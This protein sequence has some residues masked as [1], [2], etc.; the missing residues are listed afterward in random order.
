MG[1]YMALYGPIQG[2]IWQNLFGSVW[3]TWRVNL[4][5]FSPVGMF[6]YFHGFVMELSDTRYPKS[7]G[8]LYQTSPGDRY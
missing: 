1:P 6:L 8:A 5:R 3:T 7:S 4:S 2:L